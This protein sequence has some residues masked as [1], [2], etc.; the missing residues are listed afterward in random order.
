MSNQFLDHLLVLLVWGDGVEARNGLSY[1]FEEAF[2]PVFNLYLIATSVLLRGD[3]IHAG[4]YLVPF[5]QSK[6][7]K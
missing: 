6:F 2:G 4:G 5:S 7:Q 1:L 3:T